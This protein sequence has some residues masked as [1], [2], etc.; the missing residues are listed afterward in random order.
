MTIM[1]PRFEQGA[2]GFRSARRRFSGNIGKLWAE[3]SG[4][5]GAVSEKPRRLR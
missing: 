4:G 1:V 3:R 5:E 2:D